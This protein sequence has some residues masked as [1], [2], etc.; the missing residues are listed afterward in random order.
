MGP[1]VLIHKFCCGPYFTYLGLV[2]RQRVGDDAHPLGDF[3]GL[4]A[5]ARQ[6]AGNYVSTEHFWINDPDPV[7]VGGETTCGIQAPAESATTLRF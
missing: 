7:F 4:K 1:N 5:M 6:L 2:D 3:E